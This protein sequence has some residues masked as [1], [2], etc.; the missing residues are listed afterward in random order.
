[1]WSNFLQERR[2][3]PH[4]RLVKKGVG[5]LCYMCPNCIC[6]V[7]KNKLP[8]PHNTVQLRA[9]SLCLWHILRLAL[10]TCLLLLSNNVTSCSSSLLT[11]RCV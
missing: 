4:K 2:A 1:M 9:S 10:A 8:V 11:C 7:R 5:A 6:T 3:V